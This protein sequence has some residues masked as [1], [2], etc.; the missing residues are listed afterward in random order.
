MKINKSIEEAQSIVL[1]LKSDLQESYNFWTSAQKNNPDFEQLSDSHWQIK[2][3][4]CWLHGAT[5]VQESIELEKWLFDSPPLSDLANEKASKCIK[6]WKEW[7]YLQDQYYCDFP[8]FNTEKPL[9][10]EILY[11]YLQRVVNLVECENIKSQGMENKTKE[12]PLKWRALKSFLDYLR[13]LHPE[14]TTFIE[15]IFPRKMDLF[16]GR[17]RRLISAEA[18]PISQEAAA[19]IIQTLVQIATTGR[20]NRH[21]S[22]LESLGLAWLCLTASRLRLPTHL[23][24][25]QKTKISAISL[26]GAYPI[27]H[28]PTLF[29]PREVRISYRLAQFFLALSKIPSDSVRETILQRD[30][31]VLRNVFKRAVTNCHFT[32]IKGNI[33]YLTLINPPH[34]F[35]KYHRYQSNHK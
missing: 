10:G 35:G 11:D 34:I 5:D 31:R 1:G 21:L 8:E 2:R 12:T 15:Q 6:Y 24:M 33:T 28:I 14:A 32:Q 23:E 13:N 16:F 20:P 9:K 7:L 29:G 26:T 22:A 17:I 18:Y 25:I 3:A 4:R 27:I 30:P 19:D